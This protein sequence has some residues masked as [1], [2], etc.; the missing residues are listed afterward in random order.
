ME[1][2]NKSLDFDKIF[3]EVEIAFKKY[4][5]IKKKMK[6]FACLSIKNI[7]GLID[8]LKALDLKEPSLKSINRIYEFINKINNS[9]GNGK[10]WNL[11]RVESS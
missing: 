7:K 3:K 11:E 9:K 8:I 5:F 1:V 4:E 10:L 2:I 6:F